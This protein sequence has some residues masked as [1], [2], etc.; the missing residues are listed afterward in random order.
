MQDGEPDRGD[1]EVEL[2]RT[3]RSK[4]IPGEDGRVMSAA[5]LMRIVPAYQ[6]AVHARSGGVQSPRSIIGP[7]SGRSRCEPWRNGGPI[8]ARAGGATGNRLAAM[9]VAK[10]KMAARAEER[11]P[12]E[13]AEYDESEKSEKNIQRCE[14]AG[15]NSLIAVATDDRS[16]S[17]GDRRFG[18]D[19]LSGNRRVGLRPKSDLGC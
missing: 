4:W 17:V 18:S 12:Q 6:F 1:T 14:A 5:L 2:V 16:D 9:V 10:T 19:E 3:H 13:K 15:M 8:L 11:Y 7:G